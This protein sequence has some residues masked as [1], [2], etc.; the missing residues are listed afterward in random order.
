MAKSKIANDARTFRQ[1]LRECSAEDEIR[2]LLKMQSRLYERTRNT[3][4]ALR[5]GLISLADQTFPDAD[6][7]FLDHRTQSGHVKQAE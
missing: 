4:V 7:L 3:G 2:R 5:D 6:T 1:D